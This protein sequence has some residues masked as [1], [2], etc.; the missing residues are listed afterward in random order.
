MKVLFYNHT[1]QVSG[2]ERVMQ[3]ILGGLD[4]E[5]FERVVACPDQ[6]RMFEL[7]VS[8][9]VRTR[10]LRA[11]EARFTLRPDR[12][13]QYLFSFARVIREARALVVEESPDAIH[14]NSIRA[15]IVMAAATIGLPTPVIWHAHDIL[16]RHPLST[17]VRLF[18]AASSRNRILAVSHAVAKRFRGRL[19]PP[20]ANRFKVNVVHNAVDLERFHPDANGRAEIRQEL[21]LN[22]TELVIG[23]VGQL[24]PRKGQLELIK[25]FASVA[26][27]MPDVILL[28]VGEPLFNRDEDYAKRLREAAVA[29]GLT[30]RISFLGARN[31]VPKLMRAM[32]VLVVNSHEE[33]FALTVLEGLAT[34]SAVIATA[35]GGIPE[36]IKHGKNGWLV[37]PRNHALLAKG[38]FD[39]LNDYTL[40]AQFGLHARQTAVES[41]SANRFLRE[42]NSLYIDV[43]APKS[44]KETLRKLNEKL[45]TD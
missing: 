45:V 34:G 42:I 38:L 32:D 44:A 14:A 37:P 16:P 18:A 30:D 19:L 36:M 4:R 17:V 33:P 12:L 5:L 11:L 8:S 15:G 20:F 3:M 25:A 28:I 41:F 1:G 39:L 29:L 43:I 27:Q 9:G 40:R 21:D 31:D 10:G 26:R 24:T 6:S 35:V 2:A 7:A 13:V 23:S 22:D